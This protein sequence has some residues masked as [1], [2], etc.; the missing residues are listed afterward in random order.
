MPKNEHPSFFSEK[1]TQPL[2]QRVNWTK[3][4]ACVGI[5]SLLITCARTIIDVQSNPALYRKVWRRLHHLVHPSCGAPPKRSAA[6]TP[7]P[8]PSPVKVSSTPVIP[9][10]PLPSPTPQEQ[11]AERSKETT[12]PATEQIIPA[13][14]PTPEPLPAATSDCPCCSGLQTTH[15]RKRIVGASSSV[16]AHSLP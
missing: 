6:L 1:T 2:R 7:Q 12:C 8:Q 15:H 3:L 10:P 13:P 9:P 4:A 11:Q 16:V 14:T 5:L